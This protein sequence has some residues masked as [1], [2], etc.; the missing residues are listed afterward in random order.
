MVDIWRLRHQGRREGTC[1][2][3]THNT[4]SRIDYW[5]ATSEVSTWTVSVEH[6][7][8]T[9]FDHAPVRLEIALPTHT[10]RQFT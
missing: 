8:K 1:V 4:W 3:T 2:S 6:M 5:I 10:P 7:P 9:L